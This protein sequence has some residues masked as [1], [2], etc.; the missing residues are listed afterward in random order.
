MK[1][2]KIC[3]HIFFIYLLKFVQMIAEKSEHRKNR[4]EKRETTARLFVFAVEFSRFVWSLR[5]RIFGLYFLFSRPATSMGFWFIDIGNDSGDQMK[6]NFTETE[7]QREKKREKEKFRNAI[8]SSRIIRT[9]YCRKAQ[10]M[11]SQRY[12]K[13]VGN[14]FLVNWIGKR[15]KMPQT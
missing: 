7:R 10:W 11:I 5:S 8:M 9:N 12:T 15:E 2:K 14:K 4:I 1:R 6:W 13:K 3:Q